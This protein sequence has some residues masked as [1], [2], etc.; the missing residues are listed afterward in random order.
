VDLALYARVLWRFRLLM[1]AGALLAV[2][3]SV[4]AM[5][6][7]SFQGGKPQFAKRGAE[8]YQSTGTL[9]LTQK[10]FPA[11]YVPGTARVD[12]LSFTSLAATYARLAGSDEVRAL[13][14]NAG[15]PSPDGFYAI[16]AV[17]FTSGRE[18]LLP[19]INLFGSAPS[20]AE[21]LKLTN[22][23][24]STFIN[25]VSEQQERTDIPKGRRVLLEVVN[26]AQPPTQIQAPKKTLP[27]VVFLSVM[28]ATIALAFV[29]ENLRP[30]IRLLQP[31]G[32]EA[33]QRT[34]VRRSA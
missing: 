12:P 30:S 21:A 17:D 32:A 7:V 9:I 14:K 26:V 20:P 13:L 34:D 2:L 23:G 11:G 16:P 25:Y 33:L 18:N 27:I 24:M 28:F 22:M 19:M 4:L 15:A 29:L 6:S 31:E 3:L 1:L 8:V 10:G 5:Y